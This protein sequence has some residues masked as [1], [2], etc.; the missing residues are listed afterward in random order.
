MTKFIPP[1]NRFV[2]RNKDEAENFFLY[3][4]IEGTD[5]IKGYIKEVYGPKR[6]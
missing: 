3:Q 1:V 5:L 4:T 6:K 2:L